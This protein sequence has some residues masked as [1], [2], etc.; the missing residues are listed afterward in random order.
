LVGIFFSGLW[1]PREIR[2]TVH[3]EEIPIVEFADTA[4]P[5]AAAPYR[6]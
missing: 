1:L 6:T 4:I 5:A 2:T 3:G